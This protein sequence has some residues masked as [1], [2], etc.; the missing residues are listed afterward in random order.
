[1]GI[2]GTTGPDRVPHDISGA[3]TGAVIRCVRRQAGEPAVLR[4]LD[5]AHER[6]PASVLE[7]PATWSSHDELLTLLWAAEQ[8]LGDAEIGYHAG[9]ELLRQYDGT[10]T[11]DALRARGGPSALLGDMAAALARSAPVA[12]L[13]VAE[14][15]DTRAVVRALARP[16]VPRRHYLCEFT[17]GALARLPTIFGLP[18]A[19]ITE[20]E[21]QARGGRCCLYQLTWEPVRTP[22]AGDDRIRPGQRIGTAGATRSP[23]TA[24]RAAAGGAGAVVAVLGERLRRLESRL[25]GV[26][27]TAADL[28]SLEDVDQVLD[29]ITERVA[30]A[31]EMSGAVLAVQ[32]TP[33][34]PLS[35]HRFGVGADEAAAIAA[36]LDPDGPHRPSERLTV[37]VYSARRNYGHLVL[38]PAADGP[39]QL[40]VDHSLLALYAD[41]AAAAL[42][43][44]TALSASRQSNATTRAL[45]NFSRTLS[46]VGTTDE[47]STALADAVRSVGRARRAVVTLWDPFA[48][49]LVLAAVS[50]A[51]GARFTMAEPATTGV[52]QAQGAEL[53]EDS[54]EAEGAPVLVAT[55]NGTNGSQ[56]GGA[57]DAAGGTTRADGLPGDAGGAGGPG[58]GPS[59]EVEDPLADLVP[60]AAGA[61]GGS[62]DT[63]AQAPGGDTAADDAVLSAGHALLSPSS[64]PVVGRLM[65]SRDCV[66]VEPS[67][68]DPALG[69]ALG[70]EG[71]IT[72]VMTPLFSDEEF[73]GMVAADYDDRP[74]VE[75]RADRDLHE[76]LQALS[77]Q[78]VTALQNAWLLDQVGHLA[79]HDALTGLP[80]RRLLEDRVHQEIER[81][82][83]V[84]E[85]SSMFCL[86]LDRFS[87]VNEAFG[88]AVGDDL[89]REVGQRL[90]EL[91]RRQDTISRLEGDE[92]AILL[93]G[94]ADVSATAALADRILSTLQRPYVIGG[95]EVHTSASIGVSMYPE[96]GDSYD[97]LLSHAS[98]A[99]HRAKEAG[100]GTFRIYSASTNTSD[101]HVETELRQALERNELFVLYQPYIDLRTGD[102]VG[103]EALVRWRHPVRGVLE[104][105]AFIPQAEETDLIVAV[106]EFV[107]GEA[108][109]Q[110]RRWED[111]GVDLQR[112][113]VNVSTRDLVNPKFTDKVTGILREHGVPTERLEIEL[114]ERV[115][116]DADGRVQQ[117]VEELRAEGVRFS[118]DDFGTGTSSIQ[119]VASFPVST[120]KIDRSFVQILGPADQQNALASAIIAMAEKLGL[121]CVAEGVE[122][123][124]QTRILLQRGCSV[125]QGFY[126][127]PPLLPDDVERVLRSRSEMAGAA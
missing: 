63:G 51:D 4:T 8:V 44:V 112:L 37:E 19:E 94:L 69:R 102:M 7:D 85:P 105:A 110:M 65:S 89:L 47:V 62:M 127:S 68:E 41:Y 10:T 74:A 26:C 17:K 52:R 117:T 55:R 56:S 59:G 81:A 49:K 36:A 98:D 84:N 106:D 3:V 25:Q 58:T 97:D 15:E 90:R 1:M 78:A 67:R 32:A 42:D 14:V 76:R 20:P 100:R 18:S 22:A 48:Q 50:G 115:V 114:T 95:H 108:I 123:S 82:K 53:S 107:L 86:D 103:V 38:L 28:R 111:A 118:I 120:L 125:A 80:N 60:L 9:E 33:T 122:S 61:A 35:V 79:W 83:R 113:S 101:V 70:I 87:R 30:V 11:A 34:S 57:G 43:L 64:S 40:E 75:L 31:L 104:P 126:F 13:E 71:V 39:E 6:R 116:L 5:V 46:G 2:G 21:C 121:E 54:E 24:A 66:V 73:L 93:P 119:Q 16:E 109:R 27:T 92:F 45:M 77:D 72:T 12:T 124:H 96:H 99:M 29:R 23:V 88:H 91:V